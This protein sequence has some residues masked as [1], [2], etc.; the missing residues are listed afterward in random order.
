MS[1]MGKVLQAQIFKLLLDKKEMKRSEIVDKVN[2]PRTTVY[3]DL[4]RLEKKN[5]VEREWRH[6]GLRG[7]PETLWK[8][9]SEV[10]G[11]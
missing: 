3:D 1:E 4:H 9:T 8:L 5:I 11:K 2:R 10:F 7:R 6:D